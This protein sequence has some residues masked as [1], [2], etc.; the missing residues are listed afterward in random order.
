MSAGRCHIGVY[1]EANNSVSA[2]TGGRSVI[3]SQEPNPASPPVVTIDDA[4]SSMAHFLVLAGLILPL[5]LDTFALSAALGIAGIPAERRM[6]TSLILSAF[7]AGMP[8]LGF[9]VGG[10][11]GHVIGRLAGGVGGTLPRSFETD[12]AR[13]APGEHSTIGISNSYQSVI[14]R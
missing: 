5:A 8:I 12:G 4:E 2:R 13:A 3:R 1:A 6:R 7:E 9:F 11:V 14:E 10:A